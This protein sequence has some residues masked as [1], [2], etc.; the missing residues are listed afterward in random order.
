MQWAENIDSAN[1]MTMRRGTAKRIRDVALTPLRAAKTDSVSPAIALLRLATEDPPSNN[2][3]ALEG[4]GRPTS[5]L[6]FI[7]FNPKMV[8]FVAAITLS[9]YGLGIKVE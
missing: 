8:A 1:A 5:T 3:Q 7:P 4:S 9:G 6:T 2:V